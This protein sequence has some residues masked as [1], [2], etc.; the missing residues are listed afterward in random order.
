M[1]IIAHRPL[2]I[3]QKQ[4]THSPCTSAT[5]IDES[6]LPIS[7]PHSF[8]ELTQNQASKETARLRTQVALSEEDERAK[9][10]FQFKTPK[11]CYNQLCNSTQIYRKVKS[12]VD[13]NRYR[14]LC[15]DCCGSY[16]KSQ[17]CEFCEQIYG[18][19]TQ[20]EDLSNWVGCDNCER[21][22]TNCLLRIT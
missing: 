20:E 19:D 2:L 10:C 17:F 3:M 6:T 22:V 7:I 1:E 15:Y 12:R 16:T 14:F 21:W 5:K 9:T 13:K 4:D 11:K 8:D 18:K